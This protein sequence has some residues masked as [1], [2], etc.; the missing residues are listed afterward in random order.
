[1]R[2]DQASN[3]SSRL[4]LLQNIAARETDNMKK[5]SAQI[6]YSTPA[7]CESS[8]LNDKNIDV[9]YCTRGLRGFHSLSDS[10]VVVG[11]ASGQSY[12]YN[13]IRTAGFSADSTQSILQANLNILEANP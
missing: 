3:E 2:Y 8:H 6:K 1:M 13:M 11:K 10:V 5:M 7:T 12:L 9:Y 4:Q